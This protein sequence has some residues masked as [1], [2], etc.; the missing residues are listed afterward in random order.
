MPDTKAVERPVR[1][2][3]FSSVDQAREAVE[4]LR[5]NGYSDDEITVVCSDDTKEMYFRELEHQQPAGSNTPLA[6][7]VGGI[8]GATLFGLTTVGVGVATGGIPLLVAGGW[9]AWTGGVLG[10]FVGAMVTRG[11]EKEA[12]NYYDQAVV[13]GKV[14]VAVEPTTTDLRRLQL[15]ERILAAA[16]AEPVALP[17]G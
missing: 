15:A 9:G 7:T 6:A 12:A 5:E 14:L 3:V 16:G 10:G 4:S 17:E 13:R 1:A 8:V 11:I 2:A